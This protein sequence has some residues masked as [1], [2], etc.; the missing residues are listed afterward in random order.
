MKKLFILSIA[1]LALVSCSIVP[2][3]ESTSII[4]MPNPA[5]QYC[6]EQGGTLNIKTEVNGQVGY[7][8]LADGQVVEEWTLF[9]ESQQTCVPEEAQKLINHKVLSEEQIQEKTK[10]KIVRIIQPNQLV[11]AD[12]RSNRISIVVDPITNMVIKANCG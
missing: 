10:S 6:I 11:T 2:E 8:H 3:Q 1:V 7:C 12:Y 4:G 5:S 9:R